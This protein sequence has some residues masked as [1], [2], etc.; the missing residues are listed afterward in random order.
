LFLYLKNTN[1]NF[2]FS[3]STHTSIYSTPN[4]VN[5]L[6]GMSDFIYSPAFGIAAQYELEF[7]FTKLA[8]YLSPCFLLRY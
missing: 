8:S 2:L 4:L 7:L 3:I 1:K 6:L 5:G